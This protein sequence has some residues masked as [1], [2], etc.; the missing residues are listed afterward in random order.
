MARKLEPREVTTEVWGMNIIVKGSKLGVVISTPQGQRRIMWTKMGP[1]MAKLVNAEVQ[2][3]LDDKAA[4]A[5][6]TP[7]QRAEKYQEMMGS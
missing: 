4:D 7:E 6:L 3:Y 1:V 2:E 5:A